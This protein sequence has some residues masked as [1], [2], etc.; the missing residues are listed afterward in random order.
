MKKPQNE[1]R[2]NLSVVLPPVRCTVEEKQLIRTKAKQAGMSLSAYIRAV[3]LGENII[4]QET[5]ADF[6]T[7]RQL[8]KIGNNLNQLTKHYHST[9]T[10]PYQLDA[11]LSKLETLFDAMIREVK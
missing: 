5:N 9:G 8:R 1:E 4:I 10:K 11:I 7:V 6:E 3:S 2:N